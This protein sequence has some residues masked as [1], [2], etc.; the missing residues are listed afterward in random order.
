MKKIL[1]IKNAL[2]VI[3]ETILEKDKLLSLILENELSANEEIIKNATWQ[4][5]K[6]GLCPIDWVQRYPEKAFIEHMVDQDTLIS[7]ELIQN[8]NLTMKDIENLLRNEEYEFNQTNTSRG[9][10]VVDRSRRWILHE[11]SESYKCDGRNMDLVWATGGLALVAITL[12]AILI[13]MGFKSN[14]SAKIE[15]NKNICTDE[16]ARLF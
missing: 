14:K 11:P 6:S 8:K 2:G 1:T 3:E 5:C 16:R 4:N 10:T 15:T 9:D 7:G 12:T 13:F